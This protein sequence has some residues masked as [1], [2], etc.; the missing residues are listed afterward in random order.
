MA[1]RVKFWGVRGS[2]PC[3]A[4]EFLEFGGNTCCVEVEA[5]G[6]RIILDAGTGLNW[7]GDEFLKQKVRHSTILMS[8]FHPDHI[9]GLNYFKPIYIPGHTIHIKGCDTVAMGN[10]IDLIESTMA[11]DVHPKQLSDLPSE[12]IFENFQ[13]GDTFE[14]S[15]E[16]VV[17]TAGLKHPGGV[18]AYRIENEGKSVCYV[19]DTEHVEGEDDEGLLDLI[20][21]ADLV[22]YDSTYAP[23][24]WPSK[25][26]WGH[27][28]WE[29]G[30]RLC[31]LAGVRQMAMYHLSPNYDDTRMTEIE[32][33]A[34]SQWDGVFCARDGMEIRI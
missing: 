20:A 16:I 2:I 4:P 12:I 9:G 29:E 7:L 28:T 34:K 6:E 22:I 13:S 24:E 25:K 33:Q 1:M 17:R 19:T 32:N 14:I 11:A 18:T 26:G 27:S 5:A 30:V 21:K 8:H 10:V 15:P 31:K 23:E 3:T